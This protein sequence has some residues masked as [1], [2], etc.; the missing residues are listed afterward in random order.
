MPTSSGGAVAASHAADYTSTGVAMVPC[1]VGAEGLGIIR[2]YL[3]LVGHN[4]GFST[5]SAQVPGSFVLYGDPL[6][7]SLMG[8]LVPFVS[9]VVGVDVLP[10]YSYTRVYLR[11][12]SLRAHRD[13]LACEHSLTLHLASAPGVDEEAWPVWFEDSTGSRRPQVLAPGDA[14]LYRGNELLHWREPCPVDWF[15]QTFLHYVDPS[16]PA[17]CHALDG[18]TSLGVR[19][20]G[21]ATH[22]A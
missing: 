3:D 8:S 9:A 17:A 5:E 20:P 13:R 19:R 11:G 6:V 22:S 18:R 16:G 2:H 4:G 14:A 21:S 10:T 12:Q 15:V 7:D 1:L